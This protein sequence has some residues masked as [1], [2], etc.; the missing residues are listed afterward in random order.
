MAPHGNA[1]SGRPA[2]PALVRYGLELFRRSPA[3]PDAGRHWRGGA[4]SDGNQQYRPAIRACTLHLGGLRIGENVTVRSADDS[5]YVTLGGVQP[6]I[7]EGTVSSQ[8]TASSLNTL[9]VTGSTVTNEGTLQSLAG[10]LH[11]NDLTLNLGQTL[12]DGGDSVVNG[13]YSVDQPVSINGGRTWT[14]VTRWI[15]RFRCSAEV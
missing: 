12:I 3:G 11:V 15:N 1:R 8:S 4:A 9:L 10:E 5:Q 2:A 7:I 14:A 13:T 6:L